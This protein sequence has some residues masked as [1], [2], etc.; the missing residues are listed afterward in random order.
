MALNAGWPIIG[1]ARTPVAPV[2]GALRHCHPHDLGAPLV[3]HLL[4]QAGLP[5]DAVDAVVLGNA[6]GAGG[7]P[8][9]LL[10]LAAGLPER[11]QALTVDTQCCAGMDAVT[12]ACGLL[13]LGQAQVVLAG[14]A[15]AWS[16]APIRMHRTGGTEAPQPYEQPAFTPWPTRDPD[17][18][19][20]A[21]DTAAQQALAR[22]AQD[23]YALHSHAQAFRGARVVVEEAGELMVLDP[24]HLGELGEFHRPETHLSPLALD[25]VRGRRDLPATVVTA[26]RLRPDAD[27]A[28]PGRPSGAD[29]WG[30]SR[31]RAGTCPWPWA[32]RPARRG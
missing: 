22:S 12:Q 2:G 8:A 18:L 7:N 30:R 6:L 27:R 20:A 23:A 25:A 1:W 14:G 16:R 32:P 19:D 13:A 5:A 26:R 11:T 29:P 9:R 21:A 31:G 17:M 24:L 28:R 15:E 4:A 3:R 10:A